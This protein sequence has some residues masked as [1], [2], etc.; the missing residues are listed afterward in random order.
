MKLRRILLAIASVALAAV[1]IIL[2]IQIGNI[3]LH[4]TWHEIERARHSALIGL[5]L[6]N[7]L[8]IYLSTEKWRSV[9]AA[10]R[11]TSDPVPSRTAA[12]GFTSAGMA[13]GQVLP[14]QLGMTAARTFGTHFY[15]SALKRG[16]A[17]TIFE[18]SFDVIIVGFL[19]V[20]SAATRVFGGHGM[21]WLVAAAG[22]IALEWLAVGPLIRIAQWIASWLAQA[23]AHRN[24]LSANLQSFFDLLQSGVLSETLTRRLVI[25]SAARFVVVV[26]MAGETAAAVGAP[27]PL[28]HLA[29]AVPFAYLACAIAATPGGIGVN[30][31]TLAGV[32]KMFGTPFS[33]AAPWVL[34]NRVLG[35]ASCFLV[36]SFA[37][38]LMGVRKFA[39][40]GAR[41][42]AT[43]E[44]PE[45]P[46]DTQIEESEPPK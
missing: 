30:E 43:T 8:L 20:A 27:I 38:I 4:S 22:M 19:A 1:L 40:A 26:L 44:I 9:D 6:L 2:I 35:V 34:A 12:F 36:A 21:M 18:Q 31:L 17:G 25:L 16:A 41:G 23:L 45:A 10:L 3:D 37:A 29:A 11:H 13:L 15:G 24:W 5:V 14:V 39:I 46:P 42:S 33:V 7:I 28:W 32:L